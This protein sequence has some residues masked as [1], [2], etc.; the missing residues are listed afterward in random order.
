MTAERAP[1]PGPVILMT[2]YA[3][4]DL[5]SLL[6][7]DGRRALKE[8]FPVQMLRRMDHIVGICQG[9]QA[10]DI[11]AAAAQ[12]AGALICMEI[13]DGGVLAGLWRISEKAGCG[14]NVQQSRI[15]ILQETIEIAEFFDVD[16]YQIRSGGAFLI[17]AGQESGTGIKETLRRQGIP[18]ARIGNLTEDND[19]VLIRPDGGVRYLDKPRG[20]HLRVIA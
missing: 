12:N 8:R 6:A 5:T 13:P 20:R 11:A 7:D 10:A 18:A 2:G 19:K 16:P 9:P 4:T 15:P 3:G 17:A 1:L 14:L